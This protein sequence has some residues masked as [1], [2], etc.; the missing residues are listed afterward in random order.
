MISSF[1]ISFFHAFGLS[2]PSQPR[3][4]LLL[5]LQV[6]NEILSSL[7]F[8]PSKRA[9]M[10]TSLFFSGYSALRVKFLNDLKDS[11]VSAPASFS[12]LVSH[13]FGLQFCSPAILS[14]L[15]FN[16]AFFLSSYSLQ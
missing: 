1:L 13:Y 9:I 2:L 14:Y 7:L 12:G 4:K 10:I 3:G 8:S 16:A 6:P 5:I 15:H 11:S